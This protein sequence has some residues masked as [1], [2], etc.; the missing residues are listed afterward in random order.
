MLLDFALRVI[1]H[2]SVVD[3]KGIDIENELEVAVPVT[4]FVP[5]TCAALTE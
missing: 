1:S 2:F 4:V 5:P 3:V